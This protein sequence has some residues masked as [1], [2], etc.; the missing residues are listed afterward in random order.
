MHRSDHNK[1]PNTGVGSFL[2]HELL[3]NDAGDVAAVLLYRVRQ[4]THDPHTGASVD[5]LDLLLG[6]NPAEL[7]GG[8][9]VRRS[10]SRIGAA[11]HADTVQGSIRCHGRL[12]RERSS[13]ISLWCLRLA[14]HKY[15]EITDGA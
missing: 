4:L 7:P 10:G 5:Q 6:Q 3:G 9:A 13:G 12:P 15:T 2:L 1:I 11:E 8:N 14:A